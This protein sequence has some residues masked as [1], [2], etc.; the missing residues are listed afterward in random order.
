MGRTSQIPRRQK[1]KDGVDNTLISPA[2]E[3]ICRFPVAVVLLT[4][5]KLVDSGLT[6]QTNIGNIVQEATPE[7]L[8]RRCLPEASP[9]RLH[10]ATWASYAFWK[11]ERL[12][13]NLIKKLGCVCCR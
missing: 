4:F 7:R 5:G 9:E 6:R 10:F 2:K 11:M 13:E 1:Q 8:D 12:S 3:L